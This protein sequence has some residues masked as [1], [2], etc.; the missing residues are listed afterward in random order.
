MANVADWISAARLRTLPLALS[1]VVTGSA[2]ALSVDG[3]RPGVFLLAML[4]TILLQVLSN[5]ANDLGDSQNGA[6]NAERVGPM[7]AVQ[8]GDISMPQ[9]KRAVIICAILAFASG[10][11]LLYVSHLN[12]L[13]F[14]ALLAIGIAAIAAAIFY[15]AGK[16]PYG[17]RAL[18]D[19]FVFIFFGLVAVLGTL[20]LHLGQLPSL[21]A[22]L[23]AISI[24][25]LSVA[26]LHMNNTRDML[27][28]ERAG[29]I[30][31]AVKLGLSGAKKYQSMLIIGGISS[32]L[33]YVLL[34]PWAASWS[35]Y[36]FMG[37]APVFLTHLVRVNKV[38]EQSTLDPELKIVALSTFFM[39]IL[40][41][42]GIFLAYNDSMPV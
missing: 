21:T 18:G 22:C 41:A 8:S 14:M 20:T 19:L 17:Y 38:E 2:L 15:T 37:I 40:F 13:A 12:T 29:K 24:G 28:D 25:L 23:P 11:S 7:R 4:T 39:S 6:D 26:V 30:T 1:S 31:M 36:L 27:A 34:S 42:T 16:N 32:M 3:F 10:L 5:Y 9:M 35:A 33:I